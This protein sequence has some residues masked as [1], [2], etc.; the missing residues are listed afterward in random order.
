MTIIARNLYVLGIMS[1]PGV[2]WNFM[3]CWSSSSGFGVLIVEDAAVG[4]EMGKMLM[5][6]LLY[7]Q[8]HNKRCLP[9]LLPIALGLSICPGCRRIR[10]VAYD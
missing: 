8:C 1:W 7:V 10:L 5:V 6:V 3:L 9:L 2:A 4:V